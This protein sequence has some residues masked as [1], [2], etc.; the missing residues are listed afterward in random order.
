[1]RKRI[2]L[3]I[4]AAVVFSSHTFASLSYENWPDV[5]GTYLGQQPP[6]M[7][8]E[9][10]APGII[11]TDRSEINSVFAPDRDEFYFTGWTRE[12]GTKIMVTRQLDG[13]WTAPAVAPFSNDDTSVDPTISHDGNRVFFGTRRPRP[14]ET[15]IREGGFDI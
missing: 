15:G 9:M 8:A 2:L 13:R 6:G 10:F 5:S 3:S 12:T 1:M 7:R 4:S 14:G 11:S